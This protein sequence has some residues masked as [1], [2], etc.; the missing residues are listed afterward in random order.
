MPA[1]LRARTPRK[2]PVPIAP[3]ITNFP[4]P[5]FLEQVRVDKFKSMPNHK[6]RSKAEIDPLT[7]E[8]IDAV[9]VEGKEVTRYD[10][11][12]TN[13]PAPNHRHHQVVELVT[14]RNLIPAKCLGSHYDAF[15][16]KTILQFAR[17]EE[18]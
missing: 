18:S 13:T 12:P 4:D 9:P 6:N 11:R 1:C 17:K 2:D 15:N 14:G 3:Q 16:T 10:A 5:P 8:T 7:M